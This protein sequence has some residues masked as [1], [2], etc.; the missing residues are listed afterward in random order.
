M[1][2]CILSGYKSTIPVKLKLKKKSFLA[3]ALSWHFLFTMDPD[4][5]DCA[6]H[7]GV[8]FHLLDLVFSKSQTEE[9]NEGPLRKKTLT[10]EL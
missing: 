9:V 2:M 4:V 3:K 1:A 6:S 5:S 10:S 7:M 8:F